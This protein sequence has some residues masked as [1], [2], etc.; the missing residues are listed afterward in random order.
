MRGDMEGGKGEREPRPGCQPAVGAGN[1][2]AG[3]AA[4]PCSAWRCLQLGVGPTSAP[5]LPAGPTRAGGRVHTSA[6][7]VAVLPQAEEAELSI[8]D[9]DLRIDVYRWA[10][11]PACLPACLLDSPGLLPSRGDGNTGTLAA[12]RRAELPRTLTWPL[13]HLTPCCSPLRSAGG[14]GGQ[15]VNTTNS[16][17]RVTHV[18]TGLVVAIQD[19][20]SQHKNKAKALKVGARRGLR[21][22][23]HVVQ[24]LLPGQLCPAAQ[25]R[26]CLCRSL[27]SMYNVDF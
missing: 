16:A 11:L 4:C 15:H 18:P 8:R 13:P 17:V 26:R 2:W 23:W 5:N 12:G 9:E 3:S 19:E 20:R 14:A 1:R 24:G 6:A 10:C 22:G 27:G 25:L 7:S 21:M